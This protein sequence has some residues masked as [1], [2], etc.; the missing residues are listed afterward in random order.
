MITLRARAFN[1]DIAFRNGK[2]EMSNLSTIAI[3]LTGFISIVFFMMAPLITDT[4]HG[5]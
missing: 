4:T 5:I 1:D 2:I 3:T